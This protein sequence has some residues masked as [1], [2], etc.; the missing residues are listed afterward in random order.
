MSTDAPD[1]D[2]FDKAQAVF[3][4][5]YKAGMRDQAGGEVAALNEDQFREHLREKWAE[6]VERAFGGGG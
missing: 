6:Y 5:G 2:D 4:A 1:P 3:L